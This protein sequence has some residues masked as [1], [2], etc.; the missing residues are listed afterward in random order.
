MSP[1]PFDLIILY[2]NEIWQR[3][4]RTTNPLSKTTPSTAN[5]NVRAEKPNSLSAAQ[6]ALVET[7]KFQIGELTL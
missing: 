6:S 3:V 2:E 1:H 5:P 4:A 7:Q